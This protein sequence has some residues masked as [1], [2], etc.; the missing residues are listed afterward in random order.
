MVA[1]VNSNNENNNNNNNDNS[2][3]KKASELT[4]YNIT[5]NY[6]DWESDLA[7]MFYAPW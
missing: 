7:I 1:L 6:N 5:S 4:A 3:V 2:K